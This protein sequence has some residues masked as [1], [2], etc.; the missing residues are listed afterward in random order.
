MMRFLTKLN[1]NQQISQDIWLMSCNHHFPKPVLPGQFVM[2][3]IDRDF[4]LRHPFSIHRVDQ[5][6]FEMIYAV[7]GDF[8]EQMTALQKGDCLD[9]IGPLGNGFTPDPQKKFLG[10][11]GGMGV[12]PLAM[13]EQHH[14]CPQYLVGAKNRQQLILEGIAESRT[15]IY[16]EDGSRGNRGLLTDYFDNIDLEDQVVFACGPEGMISKIVSIFRN[17][18]CQVY[19]S[20]EAVM[21]CGLG[22]CSGCVSPLL[23]DYVKIC[24]DGPVFKLEDFKNG[25]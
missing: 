23:K 1:L 11:G 22:A 16:T 10:I 14:P 5:D 4:Q 24:K 20:L 2:I 6:H 21:V 13:F 17:S 3:K 7:V 19:I 8:T 18:S 9:V 15:T 12:A 25:S